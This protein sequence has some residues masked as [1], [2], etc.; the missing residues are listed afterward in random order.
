M[1]K[2]FIY[3]LYIV[4]I[5]SISYPYEFVSLDVWRNCW[6]AEKLLNVN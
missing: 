6:Y 2:K 1:S 3:N 5:I 4:R